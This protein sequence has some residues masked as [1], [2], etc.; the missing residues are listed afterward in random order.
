[1]FLLCWSCLSCRLNGTDMYMAGFPGHA[2]PHAV[3]LC[4]RLVQDASHDGGTHHVVAGFIGYDAPRAV[5]LFFVVRP[6]ILGIMAGM[7]RGVQ[8]MWCF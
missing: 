5:L 3:F 7:T 1:M 4:F 2:A 8:K 6:K